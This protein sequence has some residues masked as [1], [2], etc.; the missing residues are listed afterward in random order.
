MS[1]GYDREQNVFNKG[2]TAIV[3][4]FLYDREDK[5][6]EDDE[7][8]GVSFVVQRP[9][10]DPQPAL[11]G[12]IEE[13]GTGVLRYEDTDV[14]GHYTV[15]ATFQTFDGKK[16]VRSDFEVI[17][18]LAPV[19]VSPSYIVADRAWAKLEDCFDAED[20]GPWLQDMTLNF[21]NQAKMEQ[22]IDEALLDIN[23][24]HPPTNLG[25]DN[26][27]TV[28]CETGE[29]TQ[30]PELP[31]LTQA[32]FVQVI[33]HLIRS[34]VEQPNPV[35]A[36]IAWHDRRDY[37][38][39]WQSVYQLERESYMR[40]LAL[41]KRKFLGLGTSALLLGSKAGRLIPAPMRSRMAG[42]GYW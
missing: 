5:P 25:I 28:N 33:R 34:Y 1:L 9:G 23:L 8:V 17:D 27:V 42:R 15:V 13:D 10:E 35:G 14:L 16:S 26:F 30:L 3:R 38:Q 12:D 37:L 18:P 29:I 22:F 32:V 19:F 20:E 11:S 41:F 39:R 36:Q 6:V 21:F 31:L 24:Q 7:V 2:D 40:T 4:A